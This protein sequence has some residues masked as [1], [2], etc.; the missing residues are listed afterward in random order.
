MAGLDLAAAAVEVVGW[1]AAA[2]SGSAAEAEVRGWAEEGW[3]LAAAEDWDWEVVA[4]GVAVGAAAGWAEVEPQEAAR[5]LHL[6]LSQHSC[7]AIAG[8]TRKLHCMR[9]GSPCIHTG[10]QPRRKCRKKGQ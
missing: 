1:E 3:D 9:Q 10:S 4:V 7:A 6:F 8:C 2:D 5:C